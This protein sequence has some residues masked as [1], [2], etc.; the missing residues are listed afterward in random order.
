MVRPSVAP[1]LA[2]LGV[3][4]GT[5]PSIPTGMSNWDTLVRYSVAVNIAEGRGAALTAGTPDDAHYLGVGR[6]GRS[7]AGIGLTGCLINL[8]T[9]WVDRLGGPMLA[10]LP[11]ALVLA[12]IAAML[13][14]LA[15]RQGVADG[16]AL[17]GAFLACLGTLMWPSAVHSCDNAV[18]VLVFVVLLWAGSGEGRGRDWAIAGLAVGFA[19]DIRFS[20]NLLVLPAGILILLQSKRDFRRAATLSGAFFAGM[21]P[22]LALI[23]AWN[24]HRFGFF[25]LA[26][27][28]K[29]AQRHGPFSWLHWKGMLGL[30]LSPGKGLFWYSPVLIVVAARL[31]RLYRSWPRIV[32]V[33]V[34]MV[35]AVI[36][37]RGMTTWWPG[38]WCWGPR[39]TLPA[40][41]LAAPLVWMGYDRVAGLRPGPRAAAIA[42]VLLLI[43]MQGA[44]V[45]P[46]PVGTY[47]NRV[48]I[49]LSQ[50]GALVTVPHTKPPL[51]GDWN[52]LYFTMS[53]S[54]IV[55][56]VQAVFGGMFGG[57]WM[58]W[59][60]HLFTTLLA[61]L[62]AAAAVAAARDPRSK[63]EDQRRAESGSAV[64]A[65]PNEQGENHGGTE[66]DEKS[67]KKR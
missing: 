48:L 30:T 64:S 60:G 23:M 39:Y 62:V 21:I 44:A 53:H 55:V 65:P 3:F 2:F 29:P 10:G 5:L 8:P 7:Y 34:T 49:P 22:G 50:S 58:P 51:P 33:T 31:P 1:L 36:F 11:M 4:L 26:P 46:G 41:I 15:R 24:Y 19:M 28:V 6:D 27:G 66:A 25:L 59:F 56:Q 18:E 9:Y 37:L 32:A 14:A 57:R 20:A 13:V 42:G 12:G 47:F 61:P 45:A 35:G 40:C 43:V 63:I 38:E 52:T 16:P 17:A 67:E 54:P